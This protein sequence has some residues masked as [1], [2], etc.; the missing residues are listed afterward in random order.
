MISDNTP[1]ET[2]TSG[3]TTAPELLCYSAGSVVGRLFSVENEQIESSHNVC[4]TVSRVQYFD[5]TLEIDHSPRELS[6]YRAVELIPERNRCDRRTALDH[7]P[8]R[9]FPRT[10]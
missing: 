1:T 6:E 4:I 10:S 8:R 3:R 5:E 7:R 2:P 9:P